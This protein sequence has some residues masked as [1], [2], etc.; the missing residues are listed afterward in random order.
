M[1][2][3]QAQGAPLDARSD[4]YSLGVLLFQML[5]GRAPFIDDDAVVVMAKHIKE[6]PPELEDAAP[7][8]EVPAPLE[9][10]VR[11]ALEKLPENR[12]ANAEQMLSELEQ[13][14]SASRAVES[15]V[16][17]HVEADDLPESLR[18]ATRRMWVLG[19]L[20]AASLVV[21]VVLGLSMWSRPAADRAATGAPRGESLRDEHLTKQVAASQPA[22]ASELAP[23]A[24]ASVAPTPA[25]NA[26]PGPV[27]ENSA[28]IP[29]SASAAPPSSNVTKDPALAAASAGRT[30]H[31]PLAAPLKKSAPKPAKATPLERRGNERYGRFD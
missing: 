25:P 28:E 19:A 22:L 6:P 26:G 18:L 11:R 30:T 9:A 4:L 27:A 2:P 10:V 3:E 15:G 17:P 20:L 23:G 5:A 8:I 16:R 1:S 14:L 29:R 7:G 13:A 24:A 12:P 21:L 31:A